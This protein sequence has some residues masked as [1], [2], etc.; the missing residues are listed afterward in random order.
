LAPAPE[1]FGPKDRKKHYLHISLEPEPKYQALA[2]PSKKFRLRRHSPGFNF[3]LAKEF[4][5]Q[6]KIA[7]ILPLQ[8]GSYDGVNYHPV[9]LLFSSAVFEK[10]IYSHLCSYLKSNNLLN[11]RNSGF[12]KNRSTLTSL[13]KQEHML[14][15]KASH[16]IYQ[17]HDHY[18]LL[19]QTF[20]E[21]F[22]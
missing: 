5:L 1:Q 3:A 4:P 12:R 7:S 19:R 9:A 2:P 6:W 11:N 18:F 17:P 20:T 14:L 16:D 15:L 13:L 10:P 21:R 22:F 8:N